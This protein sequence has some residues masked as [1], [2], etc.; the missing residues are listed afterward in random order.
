MQTQIAVIGGSEAGPSDMAM[1]EAVGLAL[2]GAGAVVVCGG[3]GGVMA[4]A[5]RGAKSGAGVTV[6]LLP[7]T[8]GSAANPWVDIVIPTGIGEARNAMVVGCAAAV[9]AV[10]GEYGTLSEIAL[11]LRSGTP[12]VGIGTW[13]LTRPDG[14]VDGGIVPIADP[15]EA[16]AVAVGLASG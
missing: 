5:C 3:L 10:G 9:I 7:G 15:L 14:R 6:G 1:A 8:D 13:S 2:A 16:A 12:V 11:A 4:A